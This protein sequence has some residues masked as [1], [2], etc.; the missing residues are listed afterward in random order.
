MEQ[1]TFIEEQNPSP[2]FD[3]KQLISRLGSAY[4]WYLLSLAVFF[5]AAF[6]YL[7]YTQSY[8]KFSSLILVKP[9]TSASERI[10]GTP[11]AAG[12]SRG[13]DF[14]VNNEI[15]KL[16]SA[17]L[18]GKVVDSLKLDIQISTKGQIKL[19]PVNAD[20]LPFKIT[21]KKSNPEN[22]SP[23]YELSLFATSYRLQTETQ[24][25]TGNYNVPL[26]LGSDT[27][28]LTTRPDFKGTDYKFVFA[29]LSR[30]DAIG[31]YLERLEV[32]P[33][34]KSGQGMLQL[35]VRDE[36]ASRAQLV[37]GVLVDAYDIANLQ[38]KGKALKQEMS[39]LNS[40]INEV[41]AELDAQEATVSNF[42]AT[43]KINDVSTSANEMLGNLK[44]IDDKKNDN[45]YKGDLLDLIDNNLKAST[46]GGRDE[47]VNANGLQDAVTSDLVAKYNDV[48][49]Q[50][51]ALLDNGTDKD[52]RLEAVNAKLS[53]LRAN[54]NK[55]VTAARRELSTSNNF[56]SAQEK[57][58]NGRFE[59]LPEK[60]RNYVEVS[61]VLG[62][63]QSH[64]MFLLQ[65]K[66]DKNI[67]MASQAI[68][69]SR[70]ID[71]RMNSN[72][73]EPKPFIIYMIAL[74]I[75]LVLP[76]VIV[77]IRVL[78][79]K[80]VQS[81]RDIEA[82]TTVPIAGEIGF[83]KNSKQQVLITTNAQSVEAEQFRT[84]RT[85]ISYLAKDVASK[86]LLVTSS[87]S[88][89]GKSFVSLNMAN[90]Y[91]I[92]NKKVVLLEFDLRQPG[93]CDKLDISESTG[94]ANYLQGECEIPE[95]IQRLQDYENLYFISAGDPLPQN[96]G[97]LILNN[98]MD[99]LMK[100]LKE[101]FDVVLIDTPPVGLVSDALALGKWADLSFFVIRHRY[102]LRTALK[103]V[104]KLKAENRLPALSIVM[105]GVRDKSY[106]NGVNYGYGY[107]YGNYGYGGNKKKK[108]K[109]LGVGS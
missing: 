104:N 8:Y 98:R 14:D 107:G 34:P 59:T 50:K 62:I 54:L 40:R 64:Y 32:T 72:S 103:L 80:K 65:R 55:S 47:I 66:E 101:K 76:T 48:V 3:V 84:L 52:P 57:N 93:L 61:R 85:N 16:K 89:E 49:S 11:F 5:G 24:V 41:K 77:L 38:H 25:F 20:S 91:A 100:Y 37:S 15:S 73:R 97:E 78:T 56:L 9:P 69:D 45:K 1:P 22:F 58:L 10:G 108:R 36:F 18:M 105:N 4:L 7:R 82:G 63:K 29:Y 102:S 86:V 17:A 6:L 88:Q 92:R 96:P 83:A 109:S 43:N 106:N 2:G 21:L 75:A 68:T 28:L 31:T 99:T 27:L 19:D 46:S 67:E 42:K 60:E 51:R 90:S 44:I 81:R 23:D 39:F 12:E 26:A 79:T 30:E 33:V 70:V 13:S 95:I 74:G 94:L 87:E 71:S 53:E 35:S